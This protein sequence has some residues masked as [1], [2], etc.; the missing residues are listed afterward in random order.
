M[1]FVEK[2]IEEEV[3]VGVGVERSFVASFAFAVVVTFVVVEFEAFVDGFVVAFA[4]VTGIV[5]FVFV[6]FV[7][8]I[9][10]IFVVVII[11]AG[12]AVEFGF[13]VAFVFAFVSINFSL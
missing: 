4:V 10:V 13:V 3:E 5:A 2:G 7:A 8:A 6:A 12:V 9:F 1:V 11:L